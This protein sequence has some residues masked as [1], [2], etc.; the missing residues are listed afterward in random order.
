[1][2]PVKQIHLSLLIYTLT[3]HRKTS[4]IWMDW[5]TIAKTGVTLRLRIFHVSSSPA[6]QPTFTIDTG[7]N[8]QILWHYLSAVPPSVHVWCP[9]K[10]L[11]ATTTYIAI[12]DTSQALLCPG[13]HTSPYPCWKTMTWCILSSSKIKLTTGVGV[14]GRCLKPHDFR[15]TMGVPLIFGFP[16]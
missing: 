9:K 7:S 4:N 15:T 10:I 14:E 11:T 2:Q 5:L 3:R 6:A 8:F 12:N 16:E 13:R 1:M